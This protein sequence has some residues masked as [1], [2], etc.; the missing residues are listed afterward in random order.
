MSAAPDRGAGGMW[1]PFELGPGVRALFTD[2]SGGV[3]MAPFAGLNMSGSIGDEPAA[4]AANRR[5][6]A[7]ACGLPAGR[8]AWMQQVHGA[9]VRYLPDGQGTPRADAIFTDV[10][11][12]GLGVLVADCAPVL[13]ADPAARLV[14]AAHAGREGM[15]AGV[16]PALVTALA[17]AGADPGR[18]HA[19][20]GPAICGLC[21]EVPAEMRARATVGLPEAGC[22][23]R[24]GTA[25]IDLRAGLRAQ[26]AAAGIRRVS[27]DRRCTAETPDLYS[28]RRDGRT[29]R[30]AGLIW[31][32]R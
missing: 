9:D 11:E 10:P 29:G 23:T 32:T 8:L 24:A 26:L 25:G 6:A 5:R 19:A 4:V 15:V 3:S 30:S 12:L 7:A 16:V 17:A 31:L 14:G 18:M 27:E 13:I 20:I 21:Y 28:Y 1:R 22:V 2:R